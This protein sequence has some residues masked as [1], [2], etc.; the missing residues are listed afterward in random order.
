MSPIKRQLIEDLLLVLAGFFA[1]IAVA[2]ALIES[3]H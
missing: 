2:A 3:F 1:G